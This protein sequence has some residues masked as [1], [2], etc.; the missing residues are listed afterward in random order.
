MTPDDVTKVDADLKLGGR[1]ERD[2][3]INQARSARR[4]LTSPLPDP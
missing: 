3:W 4:R 2:G 1:I